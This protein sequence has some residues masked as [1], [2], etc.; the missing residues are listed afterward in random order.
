MSAQLG[1][2]GLVSGL[3]TQQIV[4]QLMRLERQP[5]VRLE[6]QRAQHRQADE[7]WAQMATK[8][9]GLRSAADTLTRG[10]DLAAKTTVSSSNDSA[11]GV[12]PLGSAQISPGTTSL[13]VDQLATG[14]QQASLAE[15]T[16][17]D[18]VV[19]QGTMTIRVGGQD[20]EIETVENATVQ[21]LARIINDL[22]QGAR[23]QVLKVGEDRYRLVI[24]STSTG[25]SG[26]VS[27][28]GDHPGVGAMETTQT[29]QDA[30][31]TVGGIQVSRDTNQ[32]DDLV[33]GVA[34]D[35]RQ[36]GTGPVVIGVER[37]LDAVTEQVGDLVDALN[38]V[39]SAVGTLGRTSQDPENRGPLAGD[40]TLRSI[41]TRA[42]DLVA[43]GVDTGDGVVALSVIGIELTRTGEVTFDEA[44]FR[45]A[46]DNDFDGT[47]ALL[48]RSAVTDGDHL[49]NAQMT[50]RTTSG[51]YE[52]EVTQAATKAFAASAGYTASATDE[53]FTVSTGQ[54]VAEVT[55]AADA[56]RD[57]AVA[58]IN[59][60]L[61]DAGM[62]LEA[63]A[64][65][66]GIAI[67]ATRYGSRD[68]FE[69]DGAAALLGGE[70]TGDGQDVA[71]TIGG[72]A[73]TG[74]GRRLQASDGDPRGL[75]VEITV[76]EDT[77]ANAGGSMALGTVSA[78]AGFSGNVAE[79][80]TRVAGS[81]GDVQRARSRL[82]RRINAVD[83]RID[84]FESRLEIRHRTLMRQF[85]AMEQAMARLMD[86]GQWLQGQLPPA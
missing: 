75:S 14:S 4:A 34:L 3:D 13:T 45:Q 72:E 60:A 33:D 56:T 53:T 20:L 38:G 10:G 79:L 18:A 23:A 26:A 42:R 7:A 49:A 78:S 11:V 30:L 17:P 76:D 62:A 37:D 40:T 69:T 15:F 64:D 70:L 74:N 82:D 65:G 85:T 71:G 27:V 22:D 35:L 66:A 84:R 57:E 52:V 9:Q 1:V 41:A 83:D 12:S 39:L 44:R 5:V 80:A 8:L 46:L 19:G 86:Q 29:A 48:A 6:Q 77:L 51:S 2:D 31:V 36:A 54:T 25:Q 81:D 63:R 55:V 24:T 43:Q 28:V 16:S 47:V 67:E 32:I 73:A 58:A 21:D 50:S 68:S 61:A 59:A